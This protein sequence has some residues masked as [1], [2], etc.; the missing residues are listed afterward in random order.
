MLP[1]LNVQPASDTH[2]TAPSPPIPPRTRRRATLSQLTA[3]SQSLQYAAGETAPNSSP[4]LP[5]GQALRRRSTI[6]GDSSRRELNPPSSSAIS[7]HHLRRRQTLPALLKYHQSISRLDLD[8]IIK[9]KY[10]RNPERLLSHLGD[11][12]EGRTPEGGT[13]SI[14]L[15]ITPDWEGSS[16][17]IAVGASRGT[18]RRGDSAASFQAGDEELTSQSHLLHPSAAI[19]RGG[20]G[21]LRRSMSSST[22]IGTSSPPLLTPPSKSAWGSV[23]SVSSSGGGARLGVPSLNDGPWASTSSTISLAVPMR[24]SPT[25]SYSTLNSTLSIASDI[26]IQVPTVN[27]PPSRQAVARAHWGQ[28]IE[29]V[30]HGLRAMLVFRGKKSQPIKHQSAMASLM[31]LRFDSAGG[32]GGESGPFDSQE[33]GGGSAVPSGLTGV[34][35]RDA[36]QFVTNVSSIVS[37]PPQARTAEQQRVLV[38][39]LGRLPSFA[40]YGRS[41]RRGIVQNCSLESFGAERIIVKARQLPLNVYFI[42]SG[43]VMVEG[44]SERDETQPEPTFLHAGDGFGEFDLP[45]GAMERTETVTAVTRVDLLRVDRQIYLDLV[46][47][48]DDGTTGLNARIAFLRSVHSFQTAPPDAIEALARCAEAIRF[49][50]DA[51]ILH[52]GDREM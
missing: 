17:T 2:S 49:E 21:A 43:T 26:S 5:H 15:V 28:A 30:I 1:K 38:A 41:V 40:K 50:T 3:S 31:Q 8:G 16:T 14:S 12:G 24:E 25:Q 27:T 23:V 10:D 6:Q 39:M 42:L 44:G 22:S 18:L 32:E 7:P 46:D 52:P 11:A 34:L 9:G 19:L 33:V 48:A 36:I 4:L 13:S 51:V 37:I 35:H 45:K 20:G 47:E 29:A